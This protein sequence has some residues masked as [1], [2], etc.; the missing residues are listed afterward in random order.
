MRT[1]RCA[2]IMASFALVVPLG[3]AG[4]DGGGG[5]A[6]IPTA[7][8]LGASLLTPDDLDGTWVVNAGPDDAPIPASGVLT[9]EARAMLPSLELC[10]AAS[11]ES[12][13]V[14]DG[15]T[16]MAY[17]QLDMT[18]D[19]PITP[20]DDRTGRMVFVQHFLRAG[21][22]TAL[23]AT[24]ELLRDGMKACLG[25]IDT[26]EEGPGAAT[27]MTIPAVGDD[28]YGVLTTVQEAGGGEWLLHNT[29][30]R[31]GGVLMMVDVVEIHI[32]VDPLLTAADVDAIITT[33]T[34]GRFNA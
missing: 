29:L 24:F 9:D 10:P 12:R 3:C 6:A 18:P 14:A 32:G 2:V 11:A 25:E 17:R 23:Q 27:E 28:R 34:A 20:P 30:V 21:E 8:Q 7:E 13:A 16:W 26:G 1:R 5:P 31:Q 15:L 19:D 22:P 33:A 4:E